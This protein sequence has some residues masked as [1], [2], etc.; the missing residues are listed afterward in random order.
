MALASRLSKSVANISVKTC[1]SAVTISSL[2]NGK[3]HQQ[4]RQKFAGKGYSKAG[5][6]ASAAAAS[7]GL[8]LYDGKKTALAEAAAPNW[9]APPVS[10]SM[11]YSLFERTCQ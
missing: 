2:K 1:R 11:Y 9:I 4:G 6:V 7:F 8:Y 5:L 3:E 10:R